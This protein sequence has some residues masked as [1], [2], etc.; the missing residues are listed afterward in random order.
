VLPYVSSGEKTMLIQ[1]VNYADA[2]AISSTI[3][4]TRNF[5][6]AKLFTPEN[7]PVTLQLKRRGD[8]TEIALP[9]FAVCG[10]VLLEASNGPTD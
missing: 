10:A 6:T 8:R 4:L 2:P 7:P 9:A 5:V 3:W 1:L